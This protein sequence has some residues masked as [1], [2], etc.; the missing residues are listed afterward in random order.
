MN[1][2]PKFTD[3]QLRTTFHA[4]LKAGKGEVGVDEA[5]GL[6]KSAQDGGK[7]SA[8]ELTDLALLADNKD[9][10]VTDAARTALRSFVEQNGGAPVV[11]QANSSALAARLSNVG[12]TRDIDSSFYKSVPNVQ[13]SLAS[14]QDHRLG[15]A[16]E[17]STAREIARAIVPGLIGDAA[18]GAAANHGIPQAA[19]LENALVALTKSS[20]SGYETIAGSKTDAQAWLTGH[21]PGRPV[22][23]TF[24]SAILLKNNALARSV[25]THLEKDSPAH[26]AADAIARSLGTVASKDTPDRL[27]LL[28]QL[29]AGQ[30]PKTELIAALAARG[31]FDPNQAALVQQR[32]AEVTARIDNQVQP[33]LNRGNAAFRATLEQDMKRSLDATV[34]EG[35]RQGLSGDELIT[36][37]GRKNPNAQRVLSVYSTDKLAV[38]M[39]PDSGTARDVA[40]ERMYLNQVEQLKAGSMDVAASDRPGYIENWARTRGIPEHFWKGIYTTIGIAPAGRDFTAHDLEG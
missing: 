39:A 15:D 18:R 33:I 28:V 1:I 34:K 22:A 24:E 2:T 23:S 36:Y 35:Q 38:A 9:Y 37:I 3:I 25:A 10:P 16:N 27:G 21:N 8:K 11:P 6:I 26:V 31:V 4:Q 30:T 19:A 17:A 32:A 20:L 5:R 40:V 29:A 13:R 14:L 12:P 7:V